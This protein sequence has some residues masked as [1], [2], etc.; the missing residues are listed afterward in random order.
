MARK[1][2]RTKAEKKIEA[3]PVEVEQAE[4]KEKPI[5]K[6]W[7]EVEA[8]RKCKFCSVTAPPRYDNRGQARCTA[9]WERFPSEG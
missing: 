1:K 2:A 6:E 8:E 3:E 7:I 4:V 5:E 9:C